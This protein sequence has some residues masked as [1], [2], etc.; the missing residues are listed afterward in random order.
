MLRIDK[1]N[2]SLIRLE[3]KTMRESGYW[4]R[5][6]IQEMICHAPGPFCDGIEELIWL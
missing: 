5:R 6:H 2:K 1:A 3:R 4:E